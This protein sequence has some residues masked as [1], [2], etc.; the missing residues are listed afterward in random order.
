MLKRTIPSLEIRH[1][2]SLLSR[3]NPETRDNNRGFLRQLLY[4]IPA[5]R[6]VA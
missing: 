1:A 5:S 6:R 4:G 3:E 2:G